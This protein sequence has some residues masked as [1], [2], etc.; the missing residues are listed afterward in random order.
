MAVQGRPL[1]LLEGPRTSL[2]VAAQDGMLALRDEDP[3]ARAVTFHDWQKYCSWRQLFAHA[4]ISIRARQGSGIAAVAQTS[5][6]W[7]SVERGVHI[8]PWLMMTG[9]FPLCANPRGMCP[10][11][12]VRLWDINSCSLKHT[13]LVPEGTE[14]AAFVAPGQL[15][16][17]GAGHTVLWRNGRSARRFPLSPGGNATRPNDQT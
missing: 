13:I 1:P 3:Q 5:C 11:Q 4:S 12:L 17:Q 7:T 9:L 16:T 6:P 8:S 15:V 10:G 2:M 14:A